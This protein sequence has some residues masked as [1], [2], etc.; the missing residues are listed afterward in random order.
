MTPEAVRA[1]CLRARRRFYSVPN[2]LRRA[3]QPHNRSDW[4]FLKSFLAVNLLHLAEVANAT[5][6]R[7]ATAASPDPC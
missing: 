3:M 2:T 7:S 5:R 4:R 6:C 1:A